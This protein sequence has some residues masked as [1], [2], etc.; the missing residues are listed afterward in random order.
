MAYN[1]LKKHIIFT[2]ALICFNTVCMNCHS[3]KQAMISELQD[4]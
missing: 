2:S 3:F 1:S 4:N